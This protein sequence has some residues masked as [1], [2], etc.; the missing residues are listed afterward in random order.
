MWVSCCLS[1]N[2][3][4]PT[5]LLSVWHQ[6]IVALT[7]LVRICCS[8]ISSLV[9]NLLLSLC[10]KFITINYHTPKQRE[11]KFWTK[12]KIELQ[13]I[14]SWGPGTGISELPLAYLRF[15]FEK[16]AIQVFER[17]FIENISNRRTVGLYHII[18]YK[19]SH[20]ALFL[21]KMLQGLG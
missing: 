19:F 8:S 13:H 16:C 4:T 2:K 21:S 6:A 9:L 5:Q 14:H 12:I 20:R 11:K 1:H 17:A 10:F 3:Q 15:S 18:L 7:Q